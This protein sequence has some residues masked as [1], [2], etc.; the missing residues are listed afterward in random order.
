MSINFPL[1]LLALL[2]LWFPREWMRRGAALLRR[3]RRA[4]QSRIVEPW[5]A[6]EAGDPRLNF[7]PEFAKFRN[8]LDLLRGMA[9]SVVLFGGLG[10][11]PAIAALPGASRTVPLPVM[12]ITCRVTVREA[13]G[14]A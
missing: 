2:L 7:R 8:H 3:R 5:R 12:A 11:L 14:N 6:R 4:K 9:G 13:P 1:L 10:L